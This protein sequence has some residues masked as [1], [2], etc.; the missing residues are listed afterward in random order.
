MEKGEKEKER[1]KIVAFC[2][3]PTFRW[4]KLNGNIGQIREGVKNTQRGGSINLA[5]FG[6]RYVTPPKIGAYQMHPPRKC[7]NGADP[8]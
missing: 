8:P 2:Q 4:K 6:R 7:G 3:R 1:Q 5:T